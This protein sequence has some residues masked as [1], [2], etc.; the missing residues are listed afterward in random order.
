M[1][2]D[3][4]PKADEL[5]GYDQF[6]SALATDLQ[7]IQMTVKETRAA[8]KPVSEIE[9]KERRR[10]C[11]HEAMHLDVDSRTVECAYCDARLDPFEVMRQYAYRERTWRRW[12]RATRDQMAKLEELKEQER[13]IKARVRNAARK[14]ADLAVQE[15]R[16]RAAEK[17]RRIIMHATTMREAAERIL[18]AAGHSP[19]ALTFAAIEL[20]VNDDGGDNGDL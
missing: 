1:S 5:P 8:R 6:A 4:K 12:D 20:E 10:F 19:K 18:S 2:D 3:D 17:M 11:R 7:A 15:E 14:D 13:R 9:L 16:R